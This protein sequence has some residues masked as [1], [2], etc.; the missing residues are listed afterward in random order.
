MAVSLSFTSVTSSRFIFS[1]FSLYSS[2]FAFISLALPEVFSSSFS[3]CAISF[4]ITLISFSLDFD[5]FSNSAIRS[6]ALS[7]SLIRSES[8]DERCSYFSKT[9]LC[10]PCALISSSFACCKSACAHCKLASAKFASSSA[11][12]YLALICCAVSS[13]F[14]A[15]LLSSSIIF[16]L[17]RIPAPFDCEPPVI[18]PPG[19]II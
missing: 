11:V 2:R 7:F 13:S 8:W 17:E 5:S 9:S 16:P 4:S 6:L 18:E 15:S 1:L 12:L 10:S 19:F 14:L 3:A